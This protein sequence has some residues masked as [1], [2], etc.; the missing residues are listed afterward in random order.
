MSEVKLDPKAD[1]TISQLAE[2]VAAASGI[3]PVRAA[4][5]VRGRARSRFPEIVKADPRISKVK[6]RANDGNRWPV[7]N[8]TAA[9]IILA[10]RVR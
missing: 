3:D 9:A 6:T 8:G 5:E 4:K 2:I 1:Y 7:V 10:P